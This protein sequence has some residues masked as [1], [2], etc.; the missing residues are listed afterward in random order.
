MLAGCEGTS[1]GAGARSPINPSFAHVFPPVRGDLMTM[2]SPGLAD[3]DGDGIRDI[4]FGT[5]VERVRPAGGRLRPFPDPAVSGYVVAVSGATNEILW[6]APNPRDAFTT[7]R[8]ARLNGDTVPDVVMGGR[9]GAFSAFSGSDGALLWRLAP[10]AVAR[11]PFPYNYF[12]PDVIRDA[13]GDGVSDLLVVHGGNDTIPPGAPRDPSY[14]AVISGADGA[15]LAVHQA[16]AGREMYMAPVVYER[17]GGAEW[18]I[19]GTGGETHPGAAYRAPVSSLLDDSFPRRIERLVADGAGKGVIAPPTLMELNGDDDMDIIISTFDGR[20]V[21]V[22]GATGKPLW[23]RAH[24]NEE[25]YHQPAVLRTP[26]DGRLGLLISRGTGAFPRYVGTVHRIIDAVNG[27]V[28]YEYR[29]AWY[30]AGAPLAVDL[31]GD[32]VDE[33]IFFSQNFPATHGGRIH[34]VDVASKRLITY[35]VTLNSAST[36]LVAD[37]RGTGKIELITLGWRMNESD[38]SA[39]VWRGL[40]WQLTRMDLSAPTPGFISWGGYMGTRQDAEYHPPAR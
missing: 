4:V 3:L 23:E 9:E 33:G 15:V 22:A 37:V 5:G 26:L 29:N 38:P 2:S 31:D 19:F 8:F 25:T 17:P 40:E 10:G 34:I 16:P 21:A 7:P 12:T 13:N 30:P 11:T 14:L 18:F 20:L 1:N 39:P 27:R 6:R 36:P 28:L 35:D 32:G 24:Q